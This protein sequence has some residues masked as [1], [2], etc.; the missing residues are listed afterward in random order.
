LLW[1]RQFGTNDSDAASAVAADASGVY[2]AGNTDGILPGEAGA[3]GTDAFVR[4]YD[5]DG[6][7]LWTRQFGTS[8]IDGAFGASADGSGVYVAGIINGSFLG[9]IGSFV[10][11]FDASGNEVWTL[12][13]DPSSGIAALGVGAGASG[14]YVAGETNTTFPGQ[15][16]TGGTDAF[17]ARIV[18]TVPPAVV[19][20]GAR[21]PGPTVGAA[22]GPGQPAPVVGVAP[23][24]FALRSASASAPLGAE[25]VAEPL[26]GSAAPESLAAAWP[27]SAE[28]QDAAAPRPQEV[29]LDPGAVAGYPPDGALLNELLDGALLDWLYG[30]RGT[31]AR[32]AKHG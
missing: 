16:S 19:G 28:G 2:V 32:V 4:K 22:L 30:W 6:N 26:T 13:F 18:E 17:V 24:G 14:V 8:G 21:V 15:L 9:P 27:G 10:R 20:S 23:L 11:K 5:A 3:G 31:A 25:A 29:G 12:L 1:T 7:E